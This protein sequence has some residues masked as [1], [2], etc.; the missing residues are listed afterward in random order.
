MADFPACSD[1]RS[2]RNCAGG[3]HARAVSFVPVSPAAV[4]SQSEPVCGAGG[5]AEVRSGVVL[6]TGFRNLYFYRDR[7]APG[8]IDSAADHESGRRVD[9]GGNLGVAVYG[10]HGGF[11]DLAGAGE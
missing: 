9:E 11:E 5:L 4:V 10:L 7:N 6:C 3:N 1:V 2:R 8:A